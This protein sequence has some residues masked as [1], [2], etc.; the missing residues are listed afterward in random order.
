MPE[1]GE[2]APEVVERLH[3]LP[4]INIYRMLTTVPQSL[5]PWS[6]LTGAVYRCGLDGRL[7]EI[8]ICR[9]ARTARAGYELHQHSLIARN[10]GVS[11]GELTA[12][13]EEPVVTSLDDAA[14]LVCLVADELETIA[15]LSDDTRDAV[16]AALGP[17][18]ATEL[19]LILSFYAAVARFSNAMRVP[20]EA[21]D[22]LA[23]VSNPTTR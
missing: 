17:Q 14:N 15:T 20:I 10:N 11:D 21:D 16:H 4:P 22:P 23:G 8:A 3:A 9:Q 5:I 18:Q 13:L 1:D 12:V 19:V 6:D 7:R 2:L